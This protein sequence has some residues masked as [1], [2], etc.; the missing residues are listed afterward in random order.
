MPNNPVWKHSATSNYYKFI[1]EAPF[2]NPLTKEWVTVVIYAP[3]IDNGH[4]D[5]YIRTKENFEDKF[6]FTGY[7]ID[8]EGTWTPVNILGV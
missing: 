7:E 3:V 1:R 5:I 8:A 6:I 4:S 2:K